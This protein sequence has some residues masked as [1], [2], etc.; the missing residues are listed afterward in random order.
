MIRQ[1]IVATLVIGL[2]VAG[3][4]PATAT[5]AESI[6]DELTTSSDGG[7]VGTDDNVCDCGGGSGGDDGG[8]GGDEKL[9]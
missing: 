1:I 6:N 4:G 9:R 8:G 5:P 3:A 2:L 7:D